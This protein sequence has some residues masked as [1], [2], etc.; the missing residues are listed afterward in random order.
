MPDSKIRSSAPIVWRLLAA[1]WYSAC[2]SPPDQKSFSK[3]SVCAR[4]RR[5]ANHL[6]KM[7]VHDISDS[8]S[9]SPITAWASTLALRT[10]E[11]IDRS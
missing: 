5:I 4:A 10:R 3:R 1:L 9:S 8:S 6:R 7:K 2:R 11:M